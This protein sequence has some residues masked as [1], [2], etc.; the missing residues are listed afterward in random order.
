M[1]S[2]LLLCSAA[3]ADTRVFEI[4]DTDEIIAG[5]Y[6]ET[7]EP[8]TLQQLGGPDEQGYFIYLHR[9]LSNPTKWMLGDGKNKKEITDSY[10]AQAVSQEEPPPKGWTSIKT[11][12]RQ[13]FKVSRRSSLVS[14]LEQTESDGGSFT[15]DGGAVCLDRSSNK[16]TLVTPIGAKTCEDCEKTLNCVR[17]ESKVVSTNSGKTEAEEKGRDVERKKD[18]TQNLLTTMREKNTTMAENNTTMAENNKTMGENNTTMKENNTTM[19]ENQDMIENSKRK[20]VEQQETSIEALKGHNARDLSGQI[21]IYKN[22]QMMNRPS[23]KRP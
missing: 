2:I 12:R 5:L 15:L 22:S 10:S 7:E 18:S 3:L 19:T 4:T 14:S 13:S 23:S 1:L 20:M 6:V 8:D 17:V 21:K 16:W 9:R 11:G